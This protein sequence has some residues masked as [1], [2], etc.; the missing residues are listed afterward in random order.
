MTDGTDVTRPNISRIYDYVLGGHHNFEADRAAAEQIKQVFPS[1]PRW[2][3]MNRWFLQLAAAQWV[4]QGFQHILDLGSGMP[5][6]DNMHEVAP[7]ALVL[8]TDR[9]PITVAY[10]QNVLGAN[11]R[12]RYIQA[13]MREPEPILAAADEFFQGERRVAIGC[14]GLAYF[15]DDATLSHLME[16]LHAWA[17]PGS[18]MAFSHASGIARTEANRQT[19]EAFKRNGAEMFLR[20]EA[21]VRQMVAPWKVRECK[22]L[23]AW[24]SMEDHIGET[25]REGGDADMIGLILER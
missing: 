25:D 13:D 15:L 10:A 14:I 22:T 21:T 16:T 7:D 12:V 24:L 3:R 1:Y 4:E 11:E 20:D 23:A 5:A 19:F 6:Q 18:V 17:A 9:D 8:Y 2:A